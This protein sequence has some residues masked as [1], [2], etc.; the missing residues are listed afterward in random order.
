MKWLGVRPDTSKPPTRRITSA[1]IVLILLVTSKPPTRRITN[2]VDYMLRIFASKPPTRRI[3]SDSPVALNPDASK[4]PTR[5]IT[6]PRSPCWTGRASKP[7]TRRITISPV[8]GFFLW[9]S[10][11]PTRRITRG[12]YKSISAFQQ[13]TSE[14][15]SKAPFFLPI[16]NYLILNLFSRQPFFEAKGSPSLMP[17]AFPFSGETTCEDPSTP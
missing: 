13:V 3:T 6:G 17:G 14:K 2:R 10:K 16:S 8:T 9:T 15:A 7:P 5:R 4:P 12:F 1:T 11:P